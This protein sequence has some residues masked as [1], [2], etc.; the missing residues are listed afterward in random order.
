MKRITKILVGVLGVGGT[1]VGI[2][3]TVLFTAFPPRSKPGERRV[4]ATPARL[5][6]GAYLS[7]AV[8]LCMDCHS[9]R[10]WSR[11]SGPLVPGSEGRGGEIF[12]REL[13][14]PGVFPAR[15]LTPT[16][17]GRWTDG[18]VLRAFTEGISK[19]GYPLFPIMPHPNYGRMSREDALSIVA[20]VRS[21]P[22]QP[23]PPL[24]P[25]ATDMPMTLIL[26]MIPQ[27]A[28][29]REVPPA[30]NKVAYGEYLT[31]MASCADCH[32]PM[33]KGKPLPGLAFA[34][35]QAYPL[36]KGGLVRASNLTPDPLTGIGSWTEDQFVARFKS[37]VP[38]KL[39]SVEAGAFNT[40]MPWSQY[41][42]MEE[43]DLRAIY[44]YLRT[45]P[46]VTRKVEKFTPGQ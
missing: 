44:A 13:G 19:G 16:H 12:G 35:G 33:E 34:G 21:L 10:D 32:T 40:L 42:A 37:M 2:G 36:P 30:S 6:R 41:A 7:H 14:L 29:F 43:T 3:F 24:P 25:R 17:L 15:N 18:E 28:R 38:E 5:A 46:A 31:T 8:A 11:L 39:P 22:A 26:R 23:E 1:L 9:G 20:Y 27:A 45:L 4:E